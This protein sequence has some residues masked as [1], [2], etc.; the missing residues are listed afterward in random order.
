VKYAHVDLRVASEASKTDRK[1]VAL[2]CLEACGFFF[3]ES[4]RKFNRELENSLLVTRRQ[5]AEE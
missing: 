5:V 3:F 2:F 4:Q 1:L